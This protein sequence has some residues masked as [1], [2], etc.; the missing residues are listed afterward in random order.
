MLLFGLASSTRTFERKLSRMRG[1]CGKG[2]WHVQ[3]GMKYGE[4]RC[5]RMRSRK[6]TGTVGYSESFPW[7][8]SSYPLHRFRW[9]VVLPCSLSPL[10]RPSCFVPLLGLL[11]LSCGKARFPQVCWCHSLP[12]VSQ[13]CILASFESI[14][15]VIKLCCLEKMVLDALNEK[16]NFEWWHHF[17][18]RFSFTDHTIITS[19]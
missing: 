16:P 7:F 1:T 13:G 12:S 17:R 19:S 5:W 8:D 11:R 14:S 6:P 3:E 18:G 10:A 2:H 15:S 4:I 9:T